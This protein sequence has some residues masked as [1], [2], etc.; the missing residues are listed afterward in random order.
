WPVL[1]AEATP[2]LATDAWTFTVDGLV[3]QPQS[4][5][6]DQMHT[7]P[8]STY[9]GDIH[10][11]TTWSKHDV[12]FGGVS[13]DVVFDAVKLRPNATHVMAF[14]HTGY[15]TNLPLEDVTG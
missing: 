4:W 14:C 6:W 15:T 12:T 11:V 9:Q 8:G 10:C 13:L 1:T 5:T 2:H 7:L 3:E